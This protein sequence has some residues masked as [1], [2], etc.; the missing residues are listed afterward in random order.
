MGV[1]DTT[2]RLAESEVIRFIEND[3][4]GGQFIDV[5]LLK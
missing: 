5:T 3:I 2:F 1:V 4:V